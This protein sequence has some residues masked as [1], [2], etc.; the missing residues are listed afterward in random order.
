VRRHGHVQPVGEPEQIAGVD[1]GDLH[2]LVAARHG[3]VDRLP[4]SLADLVER[5]LRDVEQV[6][7]GVVLGGVDG[8]QRAGAEQARPVAAHQPVA[9]QR[10]QQSGS[11]G[12]RQ[13][14]LVHQRGERAGL[15]GLHDDSEQRRRPVHRLTP[16]RHG[17]A[18]SRS[19]I[20]WN[21]GSIARA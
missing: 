12:L 8:E 20:M 13:A 15:A 17:H 3:E 6:L 14:Q 2:D 9:L 16:R 1:L 5:R 4:G 18:A 7:R 21:H 11:G 19:F 10:V